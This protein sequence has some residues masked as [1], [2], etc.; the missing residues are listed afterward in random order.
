MSKLYQG[1]WSR[2]LKA[3]Q[4]AK[5]DARYLAVL[6]HPSRFMQVSLPVRLDDGTTKIFTGYRVQHNNAMG[7]FK[8]GTRFHPDVNLDEVK[9]LAFLMSMKSAIVEIPYGGAKG[10]VSVDPK[11]LSEAELERLTR[12]YTEKIFEI[13]G[14]QIDVPAPDVNTNAQVMGWIVDE[15]SRLQGSFSPAAVTGKPLE[16]HGS[17]GRPQ[18]T[19]YG[20]LY[21]LQA[22]LKDYGKKL[23]LNDKVKVAVQGFGN[24]GYY[25]AE[26]A[27]K[28][29]FEVVGISDSKGGIT[30]RKLHP[31]SILQVKE[32]QGYL[33]GVYCKGTVCDMVPH[34]K[35]SSEKFLEMETDVLVLAALEN[36]ITEK[37]AS[38]IK[39]K[40]ILELGNSSI[41]PEADAVLNERGILVL[42]D[43]LANAGGVTVS[44]FEWVQNLQG[45]YWEEEEVL[46]RLK[47]K[48]TTAFTKVAAETEAHDVDFRTAAAII[49]LKRIS[50][51]VKARGNI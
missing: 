17:Q 5:V 39:A 21:V 41:S 45:L 24:V 47:K 10:G 11:T 23:K 22:A 48:M 30:G 40:V 34:E 31:P 49:S 2:L 33:A 37:N 44:Y 38:Q 29:G 51:A 18:A 43:I 27:E 32:E 13:I 1:S 50:A 26:G 8:G 15:Y 12:K 7:P 14:P 42:P 20:G 36:A 16:L 19:G 4:Y 46:T 6:E 35:I 3:N 9:N 28:A 25:F